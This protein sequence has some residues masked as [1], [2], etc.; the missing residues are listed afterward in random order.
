MK[1]GHEFSWG[2]FDGMPHVRPTRAALAQVRSHMKRRN[3]FTLVELLVVIGIIAVL[4]GIILPT[5]A[6]ARKAAAR[7]ACANQLRQVAL[8]CQMYANDFKGFIP[9]YKNYAWKWDYRFPEA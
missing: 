7:T 9:E 4:I 8:A 5:L 6:G 3:A 1:I 2:C